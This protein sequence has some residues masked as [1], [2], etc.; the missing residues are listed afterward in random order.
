LFKILK[1][2]YIGEMSFFIIGNYSRLTIEYWDSLAGYEQ[3]NSSMA[4]WAS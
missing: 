2:W 1:L 3:E 4:A